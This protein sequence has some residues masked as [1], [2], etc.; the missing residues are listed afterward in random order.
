MKKYYSVFFILIILFSCSETELDLAPIS[1]ESAGNFYKTAEEIDQGVVAAY[2]A[3]QLSG[4]YRQNYFYAMEVRSDNSRQTSTTN[5]GGVYADFDLFRLEQTNPVIEATWNDCYKG[6]QRCN[7]ILNRID[8]VENN[9][10]KDVHTG[11][12]KFLRALTYFN[13]V[14]M[15]GDVPLVTVEYSDAFEAFEIG[16]TPLADVY[17]Q[18]KSD[19]TDAA[20]LL[21]T[22][23]LRIGG[24]TQGA[25]YALLGKVYLTLG[26]YAN[27]ETVLKKVTGYSLL[28]NYADVFDI[29]NENNA[30]SVF[31]VQFT[32]GGLGEGSPYANLFAPTNAIEVVGGIGQTFGDNVPTQDLAD[33]FEDGD[34]RKDMIGIASNGGYYT[35]KYQEI[36]F[37]DR[38]GDRNC[39]VLRYADVK[40][41]LAEALN[42]QQY[43]ADGEAFNLLNEI[44][45]R[46]G[47]VAMTSA[48]VPSKEAFRAAVA[49]ER[50]IELAFENHR[51]F[52]LVR[53]GKAIEV[54]NAHTS[55]TGQQNTVEPHHMVFPIPQSQQDTSDKIKPNPGY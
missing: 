27:A 52:D 38:D 4:Q 30:E 53:T 45:G 32:K 18:I 34:T 10:N 24:A 28:T 36:P 37:S 20:A 8:E 23:P 48:S 22:N 9:T 16:R 51:W 26:E 14:R 54:M 46:A 40:L 5:S 31:E 33:A 47:L 42:E 25:A 35:K 7:V 11:E 21:K 43:V 44:R 3:L 15:F 49:Q 13:L 12:V 50:R 1:Q 6:I 19:L 17:V 55:V 29:N 41:M 39:I 2:D